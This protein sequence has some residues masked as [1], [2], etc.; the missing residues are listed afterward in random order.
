MHKGFRTT[1]RLGMSDPMRTPWHRAWL[2]WSSQEQGS[3]PS[4]WKQGQAS[5]SL[6]GIL[7][8]AQAPTRNDS[9]PEERL[10]LPRHM[11]GRQ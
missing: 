7:G 3:F 1:P 5:L 2:D 6:R 4:Q 10:G 8:A 9:S 11:G